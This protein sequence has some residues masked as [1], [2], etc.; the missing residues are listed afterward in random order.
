[1]MRFLLK[2]TT[3]NYGYFLLLSFRLSC[4]PFKS[5]C[6]YAMNTCT[7]YNF[8]VPPY[9]PP[10]TLRPC[11]LSTDT[12]LHFI[13]ISLPSGIYSSLAR[14]GNTHEPEVTL[15]VSIQGQRYA[16]LFRVS[17]EGMFARLQASPDEIRS[18]N[19]DCVSL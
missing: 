10:L 17:A 3:K 14:F 13:S 11:P 1:M 9:P 16:G 4:F 18:N 8:R 6:H 7:S 2:T 15:T 5:L 12:P 19:S